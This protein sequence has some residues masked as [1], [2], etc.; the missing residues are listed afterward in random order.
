[1]SAVPKPRKLTEAEYLAAER[2]SETRH[3]FVDGVAYAMAGASPPHNDIKDNLVIAIGG[4]LRGTGCRTGSSDQRVRAG[5]SG[6]YYYPDVVVTCGERRYAPDDP[7]TLLNPVALVEVLSDGTRN[8]D[9]GAKLRAYQQIPSLREY[10]MVATDEPVV[11]R[12]VRQPDGSWRLDA[13]VGLEAELAFES[14]PVRVPLAEVYAG[15]AFPTD[16]AGA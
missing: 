9:R 1:M 5:A 7:N 16:P 8:Y 14:I 13:F 10:V 4:R 2:A 6:G 11:E 15:V 12:I 3:E